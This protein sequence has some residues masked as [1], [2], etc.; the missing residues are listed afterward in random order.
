M[1]RLIALCFISL[2]PVTALTPVTALASPVKVE[3]RAELVRLDEQAEMRVS[4]GEMGR[5]GIPRTGFCAYDYGEGGQ[6]TITDTSGSHSDGGPTPDG[7]FAPSEAALP[8][9][10]FTCVKGQTI[11]FRLE[12]RATSKGVELSADDLEAIGGRIEGRAPEFQLICEAEIGEVT[13]RPLIGFSLTV[14][15]EPGDGS[16]GTLE[17]NSDYD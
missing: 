15:A 14:E 2:A 13:L 10:V 4:A 16:L 9:F 1:R 5:I 7:C 6:V 17:M 8:E 12:A 11:R 3:V